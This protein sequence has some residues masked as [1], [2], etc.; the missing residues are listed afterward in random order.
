MHLANWCNNK[1]KHLNFIIMMRRT[2]SRLCN[3]NENVDKSIMK[4]V[5]IVAEK[6]RGATATITKTVPRQRSGSGNSIE[7]PMQRRS[8]R[9]RAKDGGA[10]PDTGCPMNRRRCQTREQLTLTGEYNIQ[11]CISYNTSN[12]SR[13][14]VLGL[15]LRS[16]RFRSGSSRRGK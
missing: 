13:M 6:E 4:H 8:V 15:Y 10:L 3:F 1:V 5:V 16:V 9:M 14:V 11:T 2:C 12:R 7:I